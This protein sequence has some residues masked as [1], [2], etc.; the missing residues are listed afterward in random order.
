[1]P[2]V[3]IAG[4]RRQTAH[5]WYTSAPTATAKKSGCKRW[6]QKRQPALIKETK[7]SPARTCGSTHQL[8][9]SRAATIL[10]MPAR[11]GLPGNE[12]SSSLQQTIRLEFRLVNSCQCVSESTGSRAVME[13][14][15]ANIARGLLRTLLQ[16]D[17][18][19]MCW[20]VLICERIQWRTRQSVASC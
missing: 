7:P 14:S 16:D 11:L 18:L 8:G 17:E 6:S 1:M 9:V 3:R 15:F 13:L 10:S 12:I 5:I 19:T 2:R 20:R 4:G